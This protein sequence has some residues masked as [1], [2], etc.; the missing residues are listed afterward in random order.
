MVRGIAPTTSS[1]MCTLVRHL[2]TKCQCGPKTEDSVKFPFQIKTKYGSESLLKRPLF[3]NINPLFPPA[4]VV[5]C[6]LLLVLGLGM[7]GP[8]GFR[9]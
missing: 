3:L 1:I 8:G 4:S 7:R 2:K 5:P 6:M 9:F